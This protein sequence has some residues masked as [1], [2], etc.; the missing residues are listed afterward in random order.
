MGTMMLRIGKDRQKR[1][2]RKKTKKTKGRLH[3]T[4]LERKQKL[5][6]SLYMMHEQNK[7]MMHALMH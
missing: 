6:I 3:Q 4:I 7:H 5:K 1:N 2:Q